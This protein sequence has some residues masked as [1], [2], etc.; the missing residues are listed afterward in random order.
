[1]MKNVKRDINNPVSSCSVSP[2]TDNKEELLHIGKED[3]QYKR[4]NIT[5]TT[6]G[7]TLEV[8]ERI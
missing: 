7:Y 2:I 3:K 4:I 8:V 5:N 6:R 1:M